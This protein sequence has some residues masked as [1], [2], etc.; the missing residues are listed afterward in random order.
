MT[1]S[2]PVARDLAGW[3]A[4]IEALHPAS[5]EMGLE[6]VA[7]VSQRLK[8]DPQFPIIIVAGTNGKGST[9]AMLESIYQA[10]G[11]KVG[12]YTSPHFIRYNE[13]VRVAGLEVT[14]AGLVRAFEA[15]EQ[16]R[17]DVAL[18]YFEFGTLAAVRYMVE[19]GVDVGIL[20]V[21]LGGRLDAVNVFSP[22]CSIVTSVDLDHMDF[23]GNDRECIGREKAGVF[24]PDV[25][26][27]CGDDHPPSS[28]QAH[29]AEIGADLRL[30]GHEFGYDVLAE[31][32]RYQS[33]GREYHLPLPALAGD[34]QLSNAASVI[35]A[36]D[37]LVTVLPVA[38]KHMQQGLQQVALNGRFQ[39][40][41]DHPQVILDVAH[42]PHA[43]L[44]L[45]SNLAQHPV[46]GRT[47]AVFSMLADKDI[48]GVVQVVAPYIDVWHIARVEHSRGA[49][50]VQLLEFVTAQARSGSAYAHED[51][52]AAYQQA[53][54]DAGENDRIIVFGSFFTVADIMRELAITGPAEIAPHR[55][56]KDSRIFDGI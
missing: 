27:I 7:L 19:A 17:Q 35:N 14:D 1:S 10:A 55:F 34:F 15:V 11:Y 44:A 32:W 33:S 5:I 53:C 23:L 39:L 36:V 52:N 45:A 29:A 37:A 21:G 2:L 51:V 47:L 4:Y 8:L 13:R 24:R 48:A 50:V 43:A 3:L 38:L 30:I 12:C 31:G 40:C 20:E 46:S 26:A 18:T 42:N 56:N 9:C 49:S 41:R 28:L 6:R 25:P 16:A 22:V 54:N